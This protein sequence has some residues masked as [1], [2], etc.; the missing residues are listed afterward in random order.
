MAQ[1]R[2]AADVG[3]PEIDLSDVQT[4]GDWDPALEPEGLT[5]E[6]AVD[7]REYHVAAWDGGVSDLQS[8]TENVYDVRPG[9]PAVLVYLSNYVSAG[10]QVFEGRVVECNE[11]R[12]TVEDDDGATRT[13]RYVDGKG[14]CEAVESTAG[15]W[16]G[17]MLDL[18][19]TRP[20]DA[21]LKHYGLPESVDHLFE[22]AVTFEDGSRE[23]VG[24]SASRSLAN[25]RRRD[26]YV[27]Q[28]QRARG[29]D[30]MVVGKVRTDVLEAVGDGATDR[31]AS[32]AQDAYWKAGHRDEMVDAL[33]DN[34]FA[35][36]ESRVIADDLFLVTDG[37][38]Y[39]PNEC[40]E[41]GYLYGAGFDACPECGEPVTEVCGRCGERRDADDFETDPRWV[42]ACGDCHRELVEEHGEPDEH[43]GD[44]GR[45]V[46]D[47]GVDMED[48]RA[49]FEYE[50]R[51]SE[52][53][54]A[55]RDKVRA[56]RTDVDSPFG[57]VQPEPCELPPADE[58]HDCLDYLDDG[59]ND[60]ATP[61]HIVH[62]E[63]LVC[64]EWFEFDTEDGTH[65]VDR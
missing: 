58:E 30:G 38:E 40:P 37:G 26:H 28:E 2:D 32:L 9:A 16:L 63:C 3:Q 39:E 54:Q 33:V 4:R 62:Y 13:A 29:A 25:Q 10:V 15:N 52:R 27:P 20:W 7:G 31:A 6:T 12:V 19:L 21:L 23:R 44:G 65:E 57:D 51:Q 34:G 49:V 11:Y 42:R 43:R 47:G 36:D 59:R 64:G 35:L 46:T 45:L 50:G 1:S 17:T 18:R 8:P 55:A 48:E 5:P 56:R 22:L 53:E 14:R 41:C 60:P 61:E 24:W